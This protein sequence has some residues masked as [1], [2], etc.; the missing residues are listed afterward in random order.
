MG[1]MKI[2]IDESH[3]C[4][5][6]V[7]I[8]VK[9]W[10]GHYAE[11]IQFLSSGYEKIFTNYK[12]FG[13]ILA[14]LAVCGDRLDNLANHRF[15]IA[16]RLKDKPTK[17]DIIGTCHI[18]NGLLGYRFSAWTRNKKNEKMIHGLTDFKN[19]MCEL[20]KKKPYE[21]MEEMKV[22]GDGETDD[23]HES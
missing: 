16:I 19:V 20:C 5:Y 18:E 13:F 4:D 7:K 8:E 10:N 14:K 17:G 2:L 22:S 1:K 9:F 15:Y 12:K 3:G 21:N 23:K 6:P 11:G